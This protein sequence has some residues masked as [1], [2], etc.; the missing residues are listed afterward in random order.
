MGKHLIGIDGPGNYFG[1]L[2]SGLE[3]INGDVAEAYYLVCVLQSPS[4][5]DAKTA[6]MHSRNMLNG[7]LVEDNPAVISIQLGNGSYTKITGFFN[8][9]FALADEKTVKDILRDNHYRFS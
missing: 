7:A 5:Q 3:E 8:M 6:Y 1:F 2:Y 4:I 9:N